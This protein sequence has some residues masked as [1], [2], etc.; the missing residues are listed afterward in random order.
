M[1]PASISEIPMADAGSSFGSRGI[2]VHVTPDFASFAQ[3]FEPND[4]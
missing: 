1:K 4:D 3:P 2:S